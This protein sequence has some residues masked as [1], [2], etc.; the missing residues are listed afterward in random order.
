MPLLMMKYTYEVG[1]RCHSERHYADAILPALRQLSG[2]DRDYTLCATGGHT[3]ITD[4]KPELFVTITRHQHRGD[5]CRHTLRY[6]CCAIIR[7]CCC[8]C[9]HWLLLLPRHTPLRCCWL[10]HTR[11]HEIALPE[12]LMR[13]KAVIARLRDM[14][15]ARVITRW[16]TFTLRRDIDVTLRLPL[17]PP[18]LRHDIRCL[19]ASY[20]DTLKKRWHT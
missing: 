5:W 8:R 20:A 11:R 2:S 7:Y 12:L 17:P 18:L 3:L 15:Y 4:F 6:G 13:E 10:W 14:I 9:Q 16:H 1:E 19:M